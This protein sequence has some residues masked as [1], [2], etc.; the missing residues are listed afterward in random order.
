[1]DPHARLRES[2]AGAVCTVCGEGI[3]PARARLLAERDDLAFVELACHSCGVAS[4]GIVLYPDDPSAPGRLDLAAD[5]V[6]LRE[7]GFRDGAPPIGQSDVLA[8][9]RLLADH[10]GDLRSLLEPGEP[11]GPTGAAGA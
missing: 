6:A 2:L 3:E 5:A 4:L 11:G 8:M 10:A 7:A 9:R 1:M